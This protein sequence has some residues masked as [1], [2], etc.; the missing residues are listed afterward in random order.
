MDMKTLQCLVPNPGFSPDWAILLETIPGLAALELA[1]QD[2]VYH[3]EGNVLIHTR[4]VVEAIVNSSAYQ[5]ATAD[6]RFILFFACLLHDIAKPSTTVIEADTGKIRQP[7]HSARG[8]IDA[9][10][11]LWQAG[12]PFQTRE[13]ICR[14]IAVHQLPFFA[15]AGDRDGTSPEHMV[16]RL[17]WDLPVWM[18]CAVAS[19]DMEGRGFSEKRGVLDDIEVFRLL[20]EEEGCLHA[21]KA[22]PNTYTRIAYFRGARIA[23]GYDLYR[24]FE[25][26]KVVVMSGMPASGKNT[27]VASHHPSLPVVSFD[28]ARDELGLAHG[29]NEGKVAHAAIDKAKHLLRNREDFVWNATHLS[30][31]MRKKTLDLLYSYGA[32]V[33]V[34]YIEQPEQEIFRRNSLRDTSLRNR[35]IARMLLKW[36]VPTPSEAC[37]VD[38]QIP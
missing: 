9:R 27:W 13:T 33:T 16:H 12:V 19:A 22:F 26:S 4:M 24:P 8:A 25:G 7:G 34:C 17:S 28:D 37:F 11:M 14:I 20:A 36:E 31:Q 21:P 10:L 15:L 32:Q 3:S 18:L 30:R 23:P 29:K 5:S 2:P 1:P 35:D 38:Y 6:E